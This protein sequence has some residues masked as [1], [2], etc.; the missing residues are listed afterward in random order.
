MIRAV[1]L[2]SAASGRSLPSEYAP[3][4]V[5][6]RLGPAPLWRAGERWVLFRH[7]QPHRH[8]P[9][10]IPWRTHA[11]AL[12]EIGCQA[13]LLTS[14]VGVLTPRLPLD[15]PLLL[16][17]LLMPDNRLPD[18]QACTIFDPPQPQ[19]GHLVV[20]GGLFSTPL[21]AQLD[22]L[23]RAQGWPA[24]PR[25][26]FGYA[27]GPRTKTPSENRLWARWGAE[28]NSMSIGPEVVLL[29]ELAIPCA[30]L[31]VGHKYSPPDHRQRLHGEGIRASLNVGHE[32]LSKLAL[33]FLDHAAPVPFENRLY[34]YA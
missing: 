1:I 34:R 24:P 33:A 19:Q 7:G 18:G 5:E 6:T 21:N 31:V 22:A 27:P 2:G 10:Q 15:T 16:G 12:A 23:I 13:A 29:N 14:S 25:V 8:L 32:I 20:D 11:L 17:D 9:H 26:V 28:V 30:G 3:V 4:T